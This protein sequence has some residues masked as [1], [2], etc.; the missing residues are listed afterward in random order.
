MA[1]ATVTLEDVANLAGVSK[2]TA[3]RILAASQAKRWSFAS[4]TRQRV[5]DAA[6]KLGY[7]PSKLARGLSLSKTGIIGLVIPSLTDSFFPGIAAAIETCLAAKGYSV[8]LANTSG[9]SQTERA[10][11]E[12]LLA[13]R[14]DGLIVAPAQEMGDA[15]LFWELW[16]RKTPFVLI[17]RVFPQTPFGSVTTADDVGAA[18][19]VDHLLSQGRTRI[20]LAGG[21]LDISPRRLRHDGYRAA[22]LRHGIVPKSEYTVEV[23]SSEEGG[24]AALARM[25]D[26]KPPPNAV[27]CVS[28]AVAIGVMEACSAQGIR[29]PQDLAV[30]GFA[31]LPHSGLLKVG[32]TTVRQPCQQLGHRAAEMLIDCLENVGSPEQIVL[33]VELVVRESTVA[34]KG[35]NS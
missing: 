24:R 2:S 29:V 16:Q 30:V 3:S 28:D 34:E 9:Q 5:S 32:L 27:F 8:I 10:K 17:D 19:A 1:N 6:A 14:V 13:W 21:P 35:A 18:L 33:P 23:P 11:V 4:E 15:G 20:A 26:S 12:D 7:R 25:F 22:L 31:D